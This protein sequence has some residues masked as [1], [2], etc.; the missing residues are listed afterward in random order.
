MNLATLSNLPTDRARLALALLLQES[1]FFRFMDV[2]SAFEEDATDFTYRPVASTTTVSTRARGGSF[3]AADVA[4]ATPQSASQK[5]MGFSI[6]VDAADFADAQAGRRNLDQWL[7][8]EYRSRFTSFAAGLEAKIFLGDPASD[9]NSP[10]GLKLILDGTT[11]VPGLTGYKGVANAKD[12][13]SGNSLDLT[14]TT[15]YDAFLEWLSLQIA[16]VKNPTGIVVAPKLYAKLTT[17]ARA[18]GY[19]TNSVGAFGEQVEAVAGIP[20]I[21]T[22]ST[23]ILTNEP[24]DAGTPATNT[25]SMYIMAPAEGAYSIVTNSGLFVKDI[26]DEDLESKQS[27]RLITEFR[28]QNKIEQKDV[29]LRIRN[30]KV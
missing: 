16:G 15:Y 5:F 4:P 1:P 24:D 27:A 26:A 30:I 19:Y 2:A 28:G 3:T 6:D 22:L 21:K 10:K 25:T 12:A 8:R 13:G 7:D 20:L 29:V 23:S 11:D 14:V 9:A 17:I 18:K